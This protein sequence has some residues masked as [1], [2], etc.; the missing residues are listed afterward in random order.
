MT[1]VWKLWPL[2]G[3]FLWARTFFSESRMCVSM[4]WVKGGKLLA[5]KGECGGNGLD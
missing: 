1:K 4:T 3:M 5:N 2:R